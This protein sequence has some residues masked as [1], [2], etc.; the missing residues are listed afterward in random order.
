[1][2][3]SLKIALLTL[4]LDTVMY[5]LEG[6]NPGSNKKSSI[7]MSPCQSL[8]RIPS[9]VTCNYYQKL[10]TQKTAFNIIAI[11]VTGSSA[12]HGQ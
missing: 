10:E 11:N 12:L 4:G 6:Q 9:N 8:P 2:Y 5:L 3:K 1:M 7:A